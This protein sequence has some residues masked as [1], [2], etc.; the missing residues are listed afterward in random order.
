[1]NTLQRRDSAVSR[2][3]EAYEVAWKRDHN[4]VKEC[5]GWEDTVAVGIATGMLLERVERAWRERVF[6][7]MEDCTEEANATFRALF[8]TWL[9]VT[10]EILQRVA[11]LQASFA[12]IDGERELRQLAERVR[13]HLAQWEAPQLSQ[14]VGLREMT[15]TPTAANEVRRI[16]HEVPAPAMPSGPR[17][18]AISTEEFSRLFPRQVTYLGYLR[19]LEHA[20]KTAEP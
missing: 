14:A 13:H 3:V 8:S 10:D 16:L 1:M 4:A 15:L 9:D 19:R 11:K 17:P 18:Q 2:Q 5:W 12:V 6:R 20:L 7:G